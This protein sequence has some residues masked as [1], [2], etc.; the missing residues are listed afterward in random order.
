VLAFLGDE[1]TGRGTLGK[2][3][4]RI[5]GQHS[6]H[7]SSSDHFTGRFTGHLRQ[8]GFLFVDEAYAADDRNAE[9]RFKRMVTDDTLT[10]EEKGHT[11]KEEPNRLHIMMASN[12]EW[13]LP[14]GAHARRFVVEKVA[15][16][17]RQEAAWFSPIYKQMQ[18]GGWEAMLYDLLHRELG[19]WHPR[20]IVH[21]AELSKQQEQSLS[22][23]D[24]WWLELLQTGVL[25]GSDE[26][27]P[28][29]ATSNKYEK[30]IIEGTDGYGGTRTRTVWRDGLY[31]QARRS[32]PKLKNATD[33]TLGGY[34]T[35]RGCVRAWVH[36]ERGWKFPPL[37]KCR[38]DWKERFPHTVWDD[39]DIT[40]WKPAEGN[41][42]AP[43]DDVEF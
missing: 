25:A 28:E 41:D 13:M 42:A 5:F 15:D 20:Q 34:L 23:L 21:T 3:L 1:G 8:V 11:P 6:L 33:H 30:V 31:D 24:A 39:Q 10:I 43:D 7:I 16:T 35:D 40:E 22:A 9:G 27:A 26:L 18:N 17:H 29:K 4:C 12:H 2:A 14:A 32:S 19:N 36:R 37:A 38:A